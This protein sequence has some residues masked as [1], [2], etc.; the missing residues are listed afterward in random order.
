MA[1]ADPLVHHLD[2]GV[3]PLVDAA[4]ELFVVLAG[5]PVFFLGPAVLLLASPLLFLVPPEDVG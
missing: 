5:S 4:V 1:L 3:K 2:Q